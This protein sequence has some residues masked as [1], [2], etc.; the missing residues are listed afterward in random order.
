[1]FRYYTT[2]CYFLK[3][4]DLETLEITE[5]FSGGVV[6]ISVMEQIASSKVELYQGDITSVIVI[7]SFKYTQLKKNIY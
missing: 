7:G 6:L 2:P 4:N 1:M 5:G 3:P